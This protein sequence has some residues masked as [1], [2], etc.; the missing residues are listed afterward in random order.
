MAWKL[1]SDHKCHVRV[2]YVY[3]NVVRFTE[4]TIWQT[5]L[6]DTKEVILLL[7]QGADENVW[8]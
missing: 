1:N 6:S 8:T 7:E 4:V 2:S 3:L 5:L